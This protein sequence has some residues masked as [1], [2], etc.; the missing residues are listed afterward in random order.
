MSETPK[1]SCLIFLSAKSE[2]YQYAESLYEFLVG[3]GLNVFFSLKSLPSLG[4]SDYR[5]VID[6]MLD[7]CDHMIVVTSSRENAES[8]WVEAEWGFFIREK[9]SGTK[10]GNVLT[11]TIGLLRPNDLPPSLRS[12]EVLPFDPGAFPRIL[13]YLGPPKHWSHRGGEGEKN[14][15]EDVARGF[16]PVPAFIQPQ[17]GKQGIR[18][19]I[20]GVGGAGVQVAERA[21][22]SGMPWLDVVAVNTDAGPLNNVRIPNK[23][24]I[25]ETISRGL[26]AGSDP[27]IGRKAAFESGDRIAAML[28]GTDLIFILAGLG[29]GTGT[30]AAPVIAGKAL[31]MGILTA[32]IVTVPFSFEGPRRLRAA[33]GGFAELCKVCDI[34]IP[35]AGNRVMAKAVQLRD[36]TSKIIEDFD[37]FLV[38]VLRSLSG[39]IHTTGFVNIDYADLK[40][41]LSNA[42]EAALGV[43]EISSESSQSALQAAQDA[44]AS[45]VATTKDVRTG[46]KAIVCIAS[47]RA[48]PMQDV[49][50]AIDHVSS[51]LP[52]EADMLF[53]VQ[54]DP[55]LSG[56]TRV[57]VVSTDFP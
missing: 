22:L 52:S 6:Q 31:E 5:K 1:N 13:N 3:Q 26:G 24:L 40:W 23:L 29:G 37:G 21:Y 9:R 41:M 4:D 12:Y 35:V 15:A 32:G 53:G 27:A 47:D 46:R 2:D 39:L 25:G 7:R 16:H 14:E 48:L 11:V 20:I 42:G 28:A 45:G 8:P 50:E 44:L 43:A 19:K 49:Q 33:E 34:V 55:A 51:V 38:G 56:K 54:E 18:T 10:H 17:P 30:G 36:S 57:L